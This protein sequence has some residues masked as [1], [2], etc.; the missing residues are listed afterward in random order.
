[1][2]PQIHDQARHSQ[3]LQWATSDFNTGNSF[4]TRRY[5]TSTE[6]W[7]KIR[8]KKRWK[9][10]KRQLPSAKE[11]GQ[12]NKT[13]NPLGGKEKENQLTANNNSSDEEE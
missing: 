7:S 5:E 10:T 6:S 4:F 1:M 3:D 11:N 2:L 9:K 13:R 12:G 8:N